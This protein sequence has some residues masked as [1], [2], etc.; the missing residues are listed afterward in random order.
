MIT[1]TLLPALRIPFN[2]LSPERACHDSRVLHIDDDERR[3]RLGVRHH[4]ATSARV[5]DV[6][7]VAGDL[8]GVHGTDPATVYLSTAARMK[9]PRRAVGALERA[10]YEDH[11]LVR[12]LCMRRTMFVVPLHLVP[13]VQAACTDALVAAQ[14]KRVVGLIESGGIARDGRRWLREVEAQTVAALDELGEA[15][16]VELSKLVPKLRLQLTEGEGKKWGVSVGVSTRVLFLL[17]L[18]QRVVRGR[19]KGQWTSSQHRWAP[20]DTWFPDG[21]PTM[22][23]PDARAELARRWLAAFGPATTADMQWWTGWPLGQT[24]TALGAV[25]AVEVELDDGE[26]WVLPDD[27]GR[28]RAPKP[29]VALLP[30]LDSTTMGWKERR[31]YLGEH[32]GVLFDRNGNAG[33]TVWADGRVVGAWT[34]RPDGEV[35]FELVEDV[36]TETAAAIAQ[37]AGALQARLGDVR[38]KPRFPTPLQ[39]HLL[40]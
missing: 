30:A 22:P 8:V 23:A 31:W 37:D 1:A 18:E 2:R 15:T 17:S 25:D 3:A 14:R 32:A 24:R 34:Q 9:T 35:V 6:R 36:G 27:V 4:L 19:P 12:T 21:I 38:V 28:T 10:L 39:T 16:A 20:M 7:T 11:S 33:P 40:A 29:W 5:A 13:V 26:G